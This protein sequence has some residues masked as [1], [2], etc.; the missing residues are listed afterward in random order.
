MT[1]SR[2]TLE[3]ALFALESE[4]RYWQNAVGISETRNRL[5]DGAE[6]DNVEENTV[7]L[8]VVTT[9][10]QEIEAALKEEAQP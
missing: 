5:L 8:E 3:V 1:L 10:I 9:T 4:Q 7:E 6:A 2:Q